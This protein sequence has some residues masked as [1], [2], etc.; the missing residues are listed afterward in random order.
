MT[1]CELGTAVTR[2]FPTALGFYITTFVMS[3]GFH[4]F[5]TVNQSLQLQWIDKAKA[6]QTIGWLMAAGSGATLVAYGLIAGL[7]VWAG[8][9][10]FGG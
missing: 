6:P 4:Y 5:E 9:S 3:V 7:H 1:F 10:P 2:F 8:L